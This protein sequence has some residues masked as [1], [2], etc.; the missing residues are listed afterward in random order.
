[1]RA[2]HP[3]RAL[4]AEE[5]QALQNTAKATS[6]RVDVVQRTRALLEVHAGHP[7][8]QAAHAAGY[9]SGDSV[10][11]LVERFNHPGLA[12]LPIAPGRGRKARYTAPQRERILQELQR[13]PD[14][15]ADG[16]E[17]VP[18]VC[19][20]GLGIGL[21]GGGAA[22]QPIL[23]DAV[24]IALDPFGMRLDDIGLQPVRSDLRQ[25]VERMAQCLAHAR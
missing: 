12:S 3:L 18:A 2:V 13:V 24:A 6:E 14:R 4:T 17:Q 19:A 20:D 16:T 22:G 7:Y 25:Y 11:Q 23:L 8:T 5:E 21:A 9:Q 1:M 15:Q 10:S